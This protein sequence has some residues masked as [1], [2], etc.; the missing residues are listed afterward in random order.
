[1]A[2]RRTPSHESYEKF[3]PTD[4]R[5]YTLVV[6]NGLAYRETFAPEDADD[7]QVA[8]EMLIDAKSMIAD[9][10]QWIPT[11]WKHEGGLSTYMKIV[12]AVDR[13]GDDVRPTASYAKRWTLL[14]SI[15]AAAPSHYTPDSQR[16]ALNAMQLAIEGWI[17][18]G[19]N[20]DDRRQQE[21]KQAI[22]GID[23]YIDDEMARE[24]HSRCLSTL[25]EAIQLLTDEK[26][27]QS[28]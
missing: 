25:D 14:G 16:I 15:E 27:K 24:G 18:L 2:K 1:M 19:Y 9:K 28:E 5:D 7:I 10:T 13:H 12:K 26:Q 17:S 6:S 20:H 11:E 23:D 8:I 21:Q 3:E 4:D 22:V